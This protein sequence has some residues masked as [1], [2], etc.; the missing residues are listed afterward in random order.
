MANSFRKHQVLSESA[1]FHRWYNDKSFL[2]CFSFAMKQNNAI[3]VFFMLLCP[4]AKK[5]SW[6]CRLSFGALQCMRPLS[7]HLSV[8]CVMRICVWSSVLYACSLT[9]LL[10]VRT[11]N[12]ISSLAASISR[13]RLSGWRHF[14]VKTPAPPRT[15]CLLSDPRAERERELFNLGRCDILNSRQRPCGLPDN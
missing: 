1:A 12:A 6:F 2:L 3:K 10:C 7:M 4:S 14:Y 9:R 5:L 11:P 8:Y 15:G 13:T